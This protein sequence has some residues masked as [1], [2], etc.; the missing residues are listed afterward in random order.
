MRTYISFSKIKPFLVIGLLLCIYVFIS[1][2]SYVSAVSKDIS[3]SVFRLHVIANSNSTED[4]NLKLKVRDAL[5]AYMNT[6]SKNCTS[7]QEVIDMAN[8]NRETLKEI[9]LTFLTSPKPDL[10]RRIKRIEAIIKY[11]NGE[12]NEL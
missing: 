6:L 10:E 4:Q 8:A 5:L 1:A 2:L 12:Y 11:E 9:A 7:K 3:D